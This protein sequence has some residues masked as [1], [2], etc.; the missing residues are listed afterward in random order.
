MLRQ[1]QYVHGQPTTIPSICKEKSF[2]QAFVREHFRIVGFWR[3]VSSVCT[4][5]WSFK[6]ITTQLC[7]AHL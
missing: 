4:H 7:V 6:Y 5:K 2:V 3:N 1:C